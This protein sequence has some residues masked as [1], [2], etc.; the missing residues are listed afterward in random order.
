MQVHG[1]SCNALRIDTAHLTAEDIQVKNKMEL[2]MCQSV[3][4]DVSGL[5]CACFIYLLEFPFI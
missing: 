4:R 2:A 3:E 1:Q 5:V